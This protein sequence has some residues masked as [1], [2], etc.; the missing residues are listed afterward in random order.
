MRGEGRGRGGGR[1]EGRM[2][3]GINQN[4]LTSYAI[5][6]V[7]PSIRRFIK[8]L[9]KMFSDVLDECSSEYPFTQMNHSRVLLQGL[10]E[11][12]FRNLWWDLFLFIS[13]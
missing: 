12:Q 13:K 8:A 2:G 1:G 11:K 7:P 6:N 4:I 3:G 9:S 5:S 10:R